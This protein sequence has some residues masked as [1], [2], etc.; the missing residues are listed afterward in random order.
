MTVPSGRVDANDGEVGVH[1]LAQDVTACLVPARKGD[2]DGRRAVHHVAVGD[3]EAVR[4]EHEPGARSAARA[5]CPGTRGNA[6]D[7][8][9]DALDRAHDR[10]GVRV[11]QDAIIR[12]GLWGRHEISVGRAAGRRAPRTGYG[13]VAK[14]CNVE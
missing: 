7:G 1:V 11:E 6:D 9:P 8:R 4:R 2:V 5:A 10:L 12:R 14:L 13:R 3:D